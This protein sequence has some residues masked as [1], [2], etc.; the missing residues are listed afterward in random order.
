[1]REPKK[2]LSQGKEEF[3]P[4]YYISIIIICLY[5]IA[6]CGSPFSPI[7][8][9]DRIPESLVIDGL[10]ITMQAFIYRDFMPSTE[11]SGSELRAV[12]SLIAQNVS[13]FPDY[14]TGDRLYVIYGTET[15]ESGFYEE[16]RPSSPGQLNQITLLA[17]GGPKW[18]I[19]SQITVIV[20]LVVKG[21]GHKYLKAL[22][23]I[24][25]ATY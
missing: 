13:T 2:L 1:M 16:I 9:L 3:L 17:N 4:F 22:N 5:S 19:N 18:P 23:Q 24:I 7:K 10:K 25:Q 11:P 6:S 15:W 12:I 14:I 8:D 20:R 21:Q